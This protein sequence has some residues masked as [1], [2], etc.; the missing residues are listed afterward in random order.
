MASYEAVSAAIEVQPSDINPTTTFDA[1]GFDSLSKVGL[2]PELE[3]LFGCALHPEVVF[4]YP[5]V[6]SLA[7]HIAATLSKGND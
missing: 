3:R 2:V 4:D 5:T 6:E 7:D 1:M